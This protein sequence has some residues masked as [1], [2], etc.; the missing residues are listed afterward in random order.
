MRKLDCQQRNLK[1]SLHKC[2][3]QTYGPALE[4]LHCVVCYEKP[5]SETGLVKA[6]IVDRGTA[7]YLE[8]L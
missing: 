3:E 8:Q 7:V 4:T 2:R 1:K 6:N 5:E